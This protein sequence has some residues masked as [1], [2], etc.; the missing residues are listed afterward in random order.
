M[1]K[2]LVIAARTSA[3]ARI[4]AESVGAALQATH[5]DL[6][7]HYEFRAALGDQ[8]AEDAL[9]Q[10]P[11]K[12]V[13]TADFRAGLLS[14]EFDLVV[15]SWK[16]LPLD[17]GA[18]T[19]IA[20]TLPR[21]DQ[22][23]VLL[24]RRDRWPLNDKTAFTLLTSSPRRAAQL[25]TSLPQALPAPVGEIR[26]VPVRGNIPTRIN[27]LWQSLP[28]STEAHGLVVAKAALDRLLSAT[29]AQYA[30]LQAELRAALVQ[31]RWMVLPLS[32]NPTAPAQ[33]ALA[34]E[35]AAS[36]ADLLALCQTI[37]CAETF[38]NVTRE[39]AILAAHGGGCH[40]LLG[41]SVLRRAAGEIS[42][43]SGVDKHRLEPVR[44]RPPQ[45]PRA[46][47]WPLDAAENNW[48]RRQPL[49]SVGQDFI[50]PHTLNDELTDAEALWIAKADALPANFRVAD[51]QI[52]WAG[53]WKTWQRLA[54]RGV[55]VNGCTDGLGE[56]E[57]PNIDT[58]T[59]RALRWLK[60]THT[61]AMAL[62]PA[63]RMATVATYQLIANAHKPDLRGREMFYWTSGS[64][65]TR[66]LALYPWLRDKVHAC[67]LG[68]TQTVIERAG[69]QPH[70]FLSRTD[71]LREMALARED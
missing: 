69:L 42:F 30:P 26:C 36:R 71:W 41:A 61:D 56:A 17:M 27:K 52:L 24:V 16:D 46:Q 62:L 49:A 18:E 4:Q 13:F 12:G 3:L 57:E 31:C 37:N 55:W 51:A 28:D 9:W 48:F 6:L 33:G 10:M 50:L 22:R 43:V 20:A 54:Q 34:V 2:P 64:H 70:L 45:L 19:R 23:D 59:G 21:A 38:A 58:L 39:R 7:I 68:H 14:G 1:N 35:I 8:R 5:P 32:V 63:Q 65:F 67:G 25:T 44:P 53:G 15:H 60:L 66:A 40:S 47:L 29:D 11:E